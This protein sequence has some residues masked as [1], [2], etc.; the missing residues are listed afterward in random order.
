MSFLSE[1]E[2]DVDIKITTDTNNSSG[3]YPCQFCE[4]S[5]PSLSQL[6]KHEQ[7]HGDQM[8]YRCSWCARLFKHKRSRDRH[9]K[10]HTGDRRY[11]CN[12][13]E[14]AFSRSDHLK[15]HMKTHDNQK[16]YHCSE[17]SR[18]YN[19]A[20]A[21]TS[22]MQFHKRSTSSNQY[23]KASDDRK[24]LFWSSR[25]S[26]PSMSSPIPQ[27]Q[28]SSIPQRLSSN[29]SPDT[30]AIDLPTISLLRSSLTLACMY[31]AKDTFKTMEQLQLHVQAVHESLLNGKSPSTSPLNI[32]NGNKRR[33]KREKDEDELKKVKKKNFEELFSCSECTMKFPKLICLRD[34]LKSVHQQENADSVIN[35]PLCG[36]PCSSPKSYAEHYVLEHCENHQKVEKSSKEVNECSKMN[37][38]NLSKLIGSNSKPLDNYS[39]STLLCGQCG[40][41]LKDFESFRAHLA[42]HLQTNQQK[43]M[44]IYCPKCELSFQSRQD[45]LNHLMKHFLGQVMK[46]YSCEACDEFFFDPDS[47][48]KHLLESHAHHLYRCSLCRETFDSRVGIQVHFTVKHTRECS[49]YRC[50]GCTSSKNG[51]EPRENTLADTLNV[52]KTPAELMEHV[53]S[54]HAPQSHN[55]EVA[56]PGNAVSIPGVIGEFFRC[57]FCGIYCSSDIDLQ[58]H[59]ESHSTCLYRCPIC[60]EGFTVEFLL[61]KH[62]AHSHNIV[63]NDILDNQIYSVTN[64]AEESSRLKKRYSPDTTNILSQFDNINR[65]ICRPSNLSSLYYCE[66]CE[67]LNFSSEPELRAHKKL[68]H[69]SPIKLQTKPTSLQVCS[70]CG[71]TLRSRGELE[72]HTRLH[73]APNDLGKRYKCNICDEIF[74]SGAILAE[75]KLE[76]HCKIQLSDVCI[77]CRGS[78]GSEADFLEHV[79]KHSL[80]GIDPQQRLDGL[81]PHIPAHCVVCRQTLI[82]ELECQLHAKYHLRSSVDI[83]NSKRHQS[84]SLCLGVLESDDDAISLP[85]KY[86]TTTDQQLKVCKRCY[87]RHWHGLPIL[88]SLYNIDNKWDDQI[89]KSKEDE[90]NNGF[91]KSNEYETKSIKFEGNEEMHTTGT[92]HEK[93]P[94]TFENYSHEKNSLGARPYN[95]PSCSLKFSFR[96]EL[97]HH[98]AI[99]NDEKAS[100]ATSVSQ[101]ILV[102][103]SRALEDNQSLDNVIVK[104]EIIV[105]P[106]EEEMEEKKQQESSGNMQLDLEESQNQRHDE[107]SVLVNNNVD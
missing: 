73:H 102:G 18:G 75:H 77:V 86:I 43:S 48:Q 107:E 41:A 92:L 60:R 27:T 32:S 39:P 56:S 31:C 90:K 35:C 84:C 4:K 65:S 24:N 42:R 95:C 47:L 26:S 30:P 103:N 81:L 5:Y 105:N 74:S 93:I 37:I 23:S 16:P 17:C 36:I 72:A 80:E 66:F 99:H 101:E 64:L 89:S 68:A 59:L 79:Q 88:G 85:S 71:E 78:L 12:H 94:V 91:V 69:K 83:S 29:Y 10:L 82:S 54:I 61:D 38:G 62:I 97:E 15:I 104:E 96:V 8:P 106:E 70:Y 21:L 100:S 44:T 52:F 46:Q 25:G 58:R 2:A 7:S 50:S 55:D 19:T 6:K 22:H 45:M 57:C 53:A 28:S 67:G 87:I 76:K 63:E 13:C 51:E 11:R 98:L 3:P 40:A 49:V 20:A 1:P 9:V 14:A 33:R 34:H